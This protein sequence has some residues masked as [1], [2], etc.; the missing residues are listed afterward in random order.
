MKNYTQSSKNEDLKDSQII[1]EDVQH[2]N[3]E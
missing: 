1:V 2:E 3:Q